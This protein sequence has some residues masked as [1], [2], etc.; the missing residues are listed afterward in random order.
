MTEEARLLTL[1]RCAASLLPASVSV[2]ASLGGDPGGLFLQELRAVAGAVPL[3]LREFAGGRTAARAA[4][5]R[6]GLP[7]Q[8]IPMAPDRSPVWPR[9]V[10][11]SITH[12]GEICLAAVT[13]DPE[14]LGLGLDL[15]PDQALPP[16]IL[17][18]VILDEE[19]DLLPRFV[20]SAKEAVYKALYPQ[21]GQVF[22]FDAVRISATNAG[23]LA[24]TTMALGP[25]PCGTR[26]AG[27]V[28]RT[29][30]F[31]LTAVAI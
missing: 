24:T 13:Q 11:G 12:S 16:E 28:A 19:Q 18:E 15:E 30:G 14:I 6:L 8:M 4:L 27:R 1:R 9:G 23:F 31:I 22:G 17:S 5:N 2:G 29:E 21:V 20:F 26:I 7:H 25:V 10:R 3:R